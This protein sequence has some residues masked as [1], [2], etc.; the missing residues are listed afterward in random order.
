MNKVLKK[1]K[2]VAYFLTSPFVFAESFASLILFFVWHKYVFASTFFFIS[3]HGKVRLDDLCL[4]LTHLFHEKLFSSTVYI[5]FC[6]LLF[7]KWPCCF[8]FYVGKSFWCINNLLSHQHCLK[9]FSL[10]FVF[11]S[12]IFFW[13]LGKNFLLNFNF[14]LFSFLTVKDL[15]GVSCFFSST[16]EKKRRNCCQLI[17]ER[18]LFLACTY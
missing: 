6:L 16:A 3:V 2:V 12:F 5:L 4:P 15:T 1:G 9:F 18:L 13:C 17:K 10:R 7:T 14:C 11:C 8:F